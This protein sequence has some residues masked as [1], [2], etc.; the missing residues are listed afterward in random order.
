MGFGIPNPPS[1][2]GRARR[3]CSASVMAFLPVMVGMKLFRIISSRGVKSL[4]IPGMVLI[5][6]SHFP[7]SPCVGA[8]YAA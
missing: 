2:H 1:L 5:A 7:I 3:S 8:A 4:D 6:Y